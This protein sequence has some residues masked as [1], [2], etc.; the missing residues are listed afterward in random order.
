MLPATLL[1][2]WERVSPEP[3]SGC[4][5]WTGGASHGY[6]VMRV[7]GCTVRVHKEVWERLH[8]RTDLFVCH[9]CDV[10]LCCNPDHLFAGTQTDN[11]S[12]CARKG[13]HGYTKLTPEQRLAIKTDPRPQYK[14]AAAYGINQTRVSQIKRGK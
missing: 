10:P 13:R 3:N 5:L 14:I 1:D 11:M 6:G 4:W 2:I 8:G 7:D 12:D 9:K